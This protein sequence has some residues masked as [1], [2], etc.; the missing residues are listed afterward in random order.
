MKPFSANNFLAWLNGMGST[1]SDACGVLE[2][3]H[4]HSMRS[5]PS[6]SYARHVPQNFFAIGLIVNS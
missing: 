2:E 3:S 1:K 4:T 6:D 5:L